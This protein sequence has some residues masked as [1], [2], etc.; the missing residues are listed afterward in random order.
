VNRLAGERG[1]C[2]AGKEAEVFRWGG[3]DGEEPPVSGARGSGAVFFS[4]C[5]LRCLY[6]QNHPWSQG[7]AG[8]R[9]DNAR[10]AGIFSELAAAGCHNINLVSPTPWL[11]MIREAIGEAHRDGQNGIPV[12]YNTSGFERR[13]TLESCADIVDIFLTDLRYAAEKTAV[14]GSGN[15]AYPAVAREALLAMRDL[16]GDLK[17]DPEGIARSG[18]ICRLLVLPGRAAEAVAGLRWLAGHAPSTAISVMAQYTPAHLAVNAPSWNRRV[19]REEYEA[20]CAEAEKLG[21]ENGWFQ[22]WGEDSPRE[23]KGFNMPP[24]APDGR[25]G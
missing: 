6:C 16:K 18:V 22:E 13:E 9:I 2:G 5:T 17:L 24:G 3:H 10:L 8:K 4:R 25:T 15:A 1:F 14:E 7:G 20:V 12:V 19:T 11:P 21:F 23:L